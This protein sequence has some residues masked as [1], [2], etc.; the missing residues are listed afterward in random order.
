M[1]N[2]STANAKHLRTVFQQFVKNEAFS[3]VLLILFAVLA[4][5]FANIP[6]L[7]SF[8][9]I[10]NIE[11][12]I[13]IGNFNLEMSLLH[14][15]NDA[16]MAIFFLNVGLE[17]KREMLVGEL[18]EPKQAMLPI[19]AALGGMLFPAAIFLLFNH[20]TPSVNGW[21]IPMATDIAFAICIL[22]LLGKKCPLGL[23]VFLT[24]LAIVD[25]LG[26][27]IVLAVFYPT[28][29]LHLNFM[30]YAAI[31]FAILVILNRSQVK[32]AL[33]YILLGIVL[34]Y[35]VYMSGIHATIAGV[36]LAVTI[37]AKT[38]INEIKFYVAAEYLVNKFKES[39]NGQVNVLSNPEQLTVLHQLN[40][41]VDAIN[42]LMNKFQVALA[43]PVNYVIMPL[44]AISNA[45]VAFSNDI[46]GSVHLTTI[47]L[48]VLLGLLLGKPL[49][50]FSFSWLAV[51]LG[52]AKLPANT[53]WKQLFAIGIIGGIG[54][55]MSLFIDNLAF[56][57]PEMINVGKAAILITS[58][59][60]A[61]LGM[62]AVAVTGKNGSNHE[63][64]NKE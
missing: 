7:A 3:G 56:T 34:W 13:K 39:S 41:R 61:L 54:F 22:T 40:E 36:L 27:I 1:T 6:A 15:I 16:L 42:P 18:A 63:T 43:H 35:F 5:V 33:P 19:F 50:I 62:F 17:I 51:K 14:W 46:F 25:D 49:G 59:L 24:A 20:G 53:V 32:N 58:V 45:G 38:R 28:H 30:I 57:D 21:G 64:T 8:H 60:A 11:A 47:G 29:A 55:T 10:W 23:K 44:F 12:G 37:P 48:G 2:K 4:I 26:S 31:V 9:D 52:I